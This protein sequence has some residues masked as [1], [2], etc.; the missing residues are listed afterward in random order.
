MKTSLSAAYGHYSYSSNP[1]VSITNDANA[2][3][4]NAQATFDFG[5][6]RLKNYKQPGMPQQAY[7]LGLEYRDPKFWW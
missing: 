2:A 3:K 4:T 5:E 7:S 6:S 1:N